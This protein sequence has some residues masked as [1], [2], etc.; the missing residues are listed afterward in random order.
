[1]VENFEQLGLVYG[2]SWIIYPLTQP[3]VLRGELGSWAEYRKNIGDLVF[4]YDE[5][6]WNWFIHPLSGSQLYLYYRA[7]G[8][9][10][11][12]SF[13]MTFISSALFEFTVE[14][15]SEPASI[16][17]LYQTPIIGTALGYGIEMI[18]HELLNSDATAARVLGRVINPFSLL[19]EKK[20]VS[21]VPMTDFQTMAALKLTMEF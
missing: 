18:S 17:D 21:L 20:S 11:R 4:D 19:V 7:T 9:D 14:T 15:Y 5:P 1:M 16:Q 12:E 8:H 3:D 13:A 6:Q 10:R 2:A